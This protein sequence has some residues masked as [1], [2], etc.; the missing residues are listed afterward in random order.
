MEVTQENE[1]I[2]KMW[3]KHTMEYYLALKRNKILKDATT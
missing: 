2:S 3:H 1:L